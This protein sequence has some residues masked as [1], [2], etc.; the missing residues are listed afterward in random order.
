MSWLSDAWSGVENVVSDAT[1]LGAQPLTSL[2]DA[3]TGNNTDLGYST[4]AGDFIGG[5]IED[6]NN[7]QRAR[8][9]TAVDSL[10]GT[11]YANQIQY[12]TFWGD[13]ANLNVGINQVTGAIGQISM[14]GLIK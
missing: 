1:K 2:Y 12:N 5:F 9:A 13:W 6:V 11:D 7:E 4:G 8:V 14:W 3:V 10:M